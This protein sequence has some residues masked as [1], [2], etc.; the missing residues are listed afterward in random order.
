M[1]KE[2]LDALK[3]KF[4]GVSEAILGRI[5]DKIAKTATTAEEVKAAVDAYTLQQLLD[6]YGDSRATE[7]QQTAVR[8]YESKYGLKDGV[9]IEAGGGGEEHKTVTTETKKQP[10][11]AEE[12][13]AWARSL[14]ESNK[15]LSDKL[16]RMETER[17]TSARKQQLESIYGKLPEKLRK[18]YER[19]SVDGLS[20]EDFNKLV[21]EVSTEVDGILQ[22]T[23]RKGAVYGTPASGGGKGQDGELTKEQKEAVTHRDGIPGKDQQPF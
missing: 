16:A 15:Q 1:R 23:R 20:D 10:A 6:G 5:A 18:P 4:Q 19:T 22:D 21:G 7:A 8:N 14:V 11:G 9:K 2:I 13:P 12:I 17:T 3:A